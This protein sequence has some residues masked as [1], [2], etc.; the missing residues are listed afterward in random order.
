MGDRSPGR[1]VVGWE[2]ASHWL[3]VKADLGGEELA[4][5]GR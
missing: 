1:G 3:W 5:V 4:G 2:V